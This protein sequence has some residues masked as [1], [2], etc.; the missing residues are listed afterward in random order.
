V[1]RGLTDPADVSPAKTTARQKPAHKAAGESSLLLDDLLH[2][3]QQPR[4]STSKQKPSMPQETSNHRTSHDACSSFDDIVLDDDAEPTEEVRSLLAEAEQSQEV[5][6]S[7]LE[8]LLASQ[9]QKPTP[10]AKPSPKPKSKATAKPKATPKPK[11]APAPN[12]LAFQSTDPDN[13]HVYNEHGFSQ[14]RITEWPKNNP[15]NRQ[16]QC[17]WHDDCKPRPWTIHRAPSIDQLK[18]WIRSGASCDGPVHLR[19]CPV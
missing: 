1:L 17:R 9:I 8:D 3:V 14:G 16:V 19:T 10:V 6:T 7:I 15:K 13:G 4:A 5:M 2:I 11:P 18:D 12:V